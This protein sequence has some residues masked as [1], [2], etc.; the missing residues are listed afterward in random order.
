DT[1]WVSEWSQDVCSSDLAHLA[2]AL[3]GRGR[4]R[5]G[6][7]AES[8]PAGLEGR[9]EGYW[10]ADLTRPDEIAG[11]VAEARPDAVVHLAAQ[12]SAG[13]DRKRV[14]SAK[15]RDVRVR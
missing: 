1:G 10:V 2:R 6:C 13:R 7:G 14:G 3:A 5:L 9:L 8:S 12:S 4:T 15:G 11:V